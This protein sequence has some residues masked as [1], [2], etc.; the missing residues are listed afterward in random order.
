MSLVNFSRYLVNSRPDL[1]QQIPFPGAPRSSDLDTILGNKNP[2]VLSKD[3]V[4]ALKELYNDLVNICQRGKEKNV[5]L[6]IDAEYR[7]VTYFSFYLGHRLFVT[8]FSWYQVDFS[9]SFPEP[10]S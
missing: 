6:I 9:A 2:I 3:D 10:L 7:F 1:P 8:L 4:A 5:K